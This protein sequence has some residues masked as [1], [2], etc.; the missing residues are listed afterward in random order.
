[1]SNPVKKAGN[2]TN[3]HYWIIHFRGPFYHLSHGLLFHFYNQSTSEWK[4]LSNVVHP[5]FVTATAVSPLDYCISMRAA[6]SPYRFT[7]SN[8]FPT[9]Q[10]G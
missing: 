5:C 1:M 8:L 10:Q 2:E 3:T 4:C 9:E 7:T 6:L